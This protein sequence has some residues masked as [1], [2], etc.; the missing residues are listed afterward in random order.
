MIALVKDWQLNYVLDVV[1]TDSAANMLGMFN[2]EKF[3]DNYYSA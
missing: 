1:T 2:L 3:P